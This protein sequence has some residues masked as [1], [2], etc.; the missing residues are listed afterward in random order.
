MPTLFAPNTVA[1]ELVYSFG[2][3]VATNVFHVNNGGVL[4]Q[5]AAGVLSGHFDTYDNYWKPKRSAHS[6]LEV[7]RVRAVD[8]VGGPVWE[9]PIGR[10]GT[11][12]DMQLPPQLAVCVT[13]RT[14]ETGRKRRGRTYLPHFSVASLEDIGA[15]YPV[16]ATNTREFVQDACA[17][18]I[19]NLSAAGKP[20]VV[21][22]RVAPASNRNVTVAQVGRIFDTQRRRRNKL[23]EAPYTS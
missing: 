22:S 3:E 15:G 23:A 2:G 8:V 12:A 13:W 17:G 7:I 16:I 9:F 1:V 20:L 11:A 21:A 14:A 5:G 18:L 10:A 6:R 4:D 19:G